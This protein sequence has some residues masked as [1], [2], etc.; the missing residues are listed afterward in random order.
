MVILI[1]Y[2][3]LAGLLLWWGRHRSASPASR[4]AWHPYV[5]L[6]LA[7]LASRLL[8][9]AV[10][11]LFAPSWDAERSYLDNLCQLWSGPDTEHYVRISQYGY[12]PGTEHENLIVFYPLFPLLMRLFNLVLPR[13][14]LCGMVISLLC[15]LGACLLLYQLALECG[16]SRYEGYAAV[17]FLLAYPFSVFLMSCYTEALFLL[18][19]LSCALL[20]RRGKWLWAGV[21]GFLAALTRLQGVLI[22]VMAVYEFFRQRKGRLRAQDAPALG[23]LLIPAGFAVY[24]TINQVLYGDAFAY[25]AFEKAAPWYQGT[26]WFFR[27][28]T[29]HATMATQYPGLAPLIY[30][31]QIVLFFVVLGLMV[32]GMR[33]RLRTSLLLYGA[34]CLLV[35]YTASWLISGGRY[36]LAIFPLYLC[37]AR[38]SQRRRLVGGLVALGSVWLMIFYYV[39]FLQGQ[40]IM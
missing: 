1:V 22:L 24:L 25:L 15:T 40:A 39:G 2:A 8:L 26:D 7:V 29:Q 32:Y 6:L 31:P 35:S 17:F 33:Q 12:E 34:I 19:T 38:L 3:I 11:P 30:V 20:L 5:V 37:L 13:P 23:L 4:S 28:L 27:N 16:M 10:S 21:V 18:L 14:E 36:V 9:Y